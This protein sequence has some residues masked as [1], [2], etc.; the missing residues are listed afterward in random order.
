MGVGPSSPKRRGKPGPNQSLICSFGPGFLGE[1]LSTP[2][3]TGGRLPFGR[4]DGQTTVITVTVHRL[5]T[6]CS[7]ALWYVLLRGVFH[8]LLYL[9]AV[10]LCVTLCVVRGLPCEARTS[11]RGHTKT[12]NVLFRKL[13]GVKKLDSSNMFQY[14]PISTSNMCRILI[15]I[16]NISLGT[17]LDLRKATNAKLK[18]K[19][20]KKKHGRLEA[21]PDLTKTTT[22]CF[23][24]TRRTTHRVLGP[25]LWFRTGVRSSGGSS[26][27][28]S[29]EGEGLFGGKRMGVRC[30]V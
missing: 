7:L 6:P 9:L 30:W 21:I 16:L 1:M 12:R 5:K 13:W 15:S 2:D 22:S 19:K 27:G 28:G 4:D 14:H 29:S 11:F 23:K 8:R 18:R 10:W 20:K 26:R 17:V 3:S 25:K 24:R